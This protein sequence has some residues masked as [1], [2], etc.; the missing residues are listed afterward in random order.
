MRDAKQATD[1]GRDIVLAE[2]SVEPD[3]GVAQGGDDQEHVLDRRGTVLHGEGDVV[4][5]RSRVD[6]AGDHRLGR[7]GD[8]LVDNLGNL[9]KQV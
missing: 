3:G 7:V 1:P 8:R 4:Q 2:H 5:D 9:G 6:H